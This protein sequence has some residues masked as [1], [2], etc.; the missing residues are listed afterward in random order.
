MTKISLHQKNKQISGSKRKAWPLPVLKAHFVGV[1][2]SQLF[3]S[4][5]VISIGLGFYTA[6]SVVKKITKSDED[7]K[8]GLLIL[9][10][11]LLICRLF[12]F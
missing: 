12:T 10:P 6:A 3:P 4:W 7:D 1:V 11:R 8:K 5:K 9:K 2:L